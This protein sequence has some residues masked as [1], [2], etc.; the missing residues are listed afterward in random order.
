[1]VT[2]GFN[3][4]NVQSKPLVQNVWHLWM[5]VIVVIIKTHLFILLLWSSQGQPEERGNEDLKFIINLRYFKIQFPLYHFIDWSKLNCRST[6]KTRNAA[7]NRTNFKLWTFMV[8]RVRNFVTHSQIVNNHRTSFLTYFI[9]LM[10]GGYEVIR[11]FTRELEEGLMVN[12]QIFH[13]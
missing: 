12:L 2:F 9:I 10:R 11:E 1:M 7:K 5:V 13:A 8:S 6:P 3:I 4:R